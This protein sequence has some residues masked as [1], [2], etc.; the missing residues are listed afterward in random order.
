MITAAG[1]HQLAAT[2]SIQDSD[3]AGAAAGFFC[4]T[5]VGARTGAGADVLSAG[6][7]TGVA[8]GAGGEDAGGGA[9]LTDGA[10]LV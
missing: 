1:T 4:R 10:G 2:Q 6:G 5:G 9:A 8:V 3:A 7:G